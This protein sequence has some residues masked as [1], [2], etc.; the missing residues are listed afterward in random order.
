MHGRT[1]LDESKPIAK[2]PR[3]YADD[4]GETR[5]HARARITSTVEPRQ[6]GRFALTPESRR[7]Q[8]THPSTNP[9][10]AVGV[11]LIDQR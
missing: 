5:R 6:S 9:D 1:L 3:I 10:V 7:L 11:S 8:A 2:F 4:R